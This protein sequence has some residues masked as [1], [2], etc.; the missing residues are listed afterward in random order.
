MEK[1][2]L[3]QKVVHIEFNTSSTLN[4]FKA[5]LKSK[6]GSQ[7]KNIFIA[8]SL[9]GMA[10]FFSGCS[11][12]YVASEPSYSYYDRPVQPHNLS[13]WID[14][15][16]DWNNR[17]QT[18]YQRNGY[19][20]NPRQ[21]QTYVSGYWQSTPKGKTWTKGGWHSDSDRKRKH[22]HHHNNNYNNQY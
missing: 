17:S 20:E 14:G 12:G 10:L 8:A 13:V 1:N 19:W 6:T 16:W 18:Y 5:K 3:V 22:N 21:G 11:A 7:L 4:A 9:A 15:E 2:D